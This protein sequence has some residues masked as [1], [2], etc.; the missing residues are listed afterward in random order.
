MNL[1]GDQAVAEALDAAHGKAKSAY[2]RRDSRMYME[3][4]AADL[5]Y[6]QAD[7]KVIGR[8]QLAKDVRAQLSMLDSAETSFTREKLEIVGQ[9]ATELLRQRATVTTR[10]FAIIRRTWNIERLGK[11]VWRN[12]D[13]GW[14]IQ[15]VEVLKETIT[16]TGNRLAWR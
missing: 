12:T 16:S 4:F 7:G 10:H 11:Y 3:I 9:Q 14:R 5:T 13:E 15:E 6:C 8:D 1:E 2:R